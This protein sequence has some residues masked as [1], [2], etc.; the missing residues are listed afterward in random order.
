MVRSAFLVGLDASLPLFPPLPLSPPPL[1]PLVGR[2]QRCSPKPAN[3][4]MLRSFMM[5]MLLYALSQETT[6]IVSMVFSRSKV[7][8][9]EVFLFQRLDAERRGQMLHLKVTH[10]PPL[11]AVSGRAYAPFRR[12]SSSFA[13]RGRMWR[14]WP[15]SYVILC[16]GSITSSSRLPSP[17]ISSFIHPPQ[18]DWHA[19]K[20]SS[21]SSCPYHP[22]HS[23]HPY[24][25]SVRATNTHALEAQGTHSRPPHQ[26]PSGLTPGARRTYSPTTRSAHWRRRTSL[27]WSNRFTS[28][29]GTFM[30]SHRQRLLSP[31]RPTPRLRPP[32]RTGRGT[33]SLRC[34]WR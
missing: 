32:W 31:S 19:W 29:T 25:H 26:H 3:R 23:S 21:H 28:I 15:R 7:L 6:V 13:R 8:E 11:A 5:R 33:G 9:K 1:L 4:R 30:R 12:L 18:R 17:P 27:S 10:A 16:L 14:C 2:A 34:C 24:H 20:I 22:F